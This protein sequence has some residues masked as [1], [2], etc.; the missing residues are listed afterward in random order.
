M[1]TLYGKQVLN[2]YIMMTLAIVI[3][4]VYKMNSAHLGI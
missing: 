4:V 3:Q 1:H 2:F